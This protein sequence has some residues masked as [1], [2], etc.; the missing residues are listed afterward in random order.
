MTKFRKA[1]S[2]DVD[3]VFQLINELEDGKLDKDRFC[4]VFENNLLDPNI[5]YILAID[6]SAIAGFLS[7]HIQEL[8]HHTGKVAEIQELFIDEEM[9]GQG[10]GEKLVNEARR[11]AAEEQCI[12]I[13]VSTNIKRER[14]QKFYEEKARF[15]KTHYKFTDKI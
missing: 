2:S 12:L 3:K 5:N 6:N 4:G 11:I 9:R 13:E 10:I 1:K 14:A 15:R 7:L 8:L